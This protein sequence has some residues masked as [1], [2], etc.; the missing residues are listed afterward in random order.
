MPLQ[1]GLLGFPLGHSLSPQIHTAFLK[2]HKLAGFYRLVETPP[3]QLAEQV[4]QL[5]E[6]N[7][8]G[9]N[10]TIPHKVAMKSLVDKLDSSVEQIGA[11]NTVV[12]TQQSNITT[13]YNTDGEGFWQSL[14]Q[15]VRETLYQRPVCVLGAGGSARAVV[16]T[17]AQHGC[18]SL[19]IVARSPNKA[20]PLAQLAESMGV[21]HSDVV[22]LDDSADLHSTLNL[23]QLVV[24]T[25]PVGMWPELDASP[26]GLEALL[27]LPKSAL[28]V[29]LI[30]KP[31]VTQLLQYSE[32]LGLATQNGLGML[33]NQAALAF[34]LWT[35]HEIDEAVRHTVHETLLL[36]QAKVVDTP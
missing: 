12:H 30:Y 13:G 17:L 18:P 6:Q 21:S 2:H 10:I 15:E 28:V 3:A 7:Y 29:D 8:R 32:S 25:T 24:N 11:V 26:L 19:T 34:E 23:A 16:A 33:V 1:L 35:G 14:P 5:K 22:A 31:L 36:Q 4:E 20:T 9:W 27:C